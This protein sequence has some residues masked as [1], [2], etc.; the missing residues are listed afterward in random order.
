M[1]EVA[2]Q[3]NVVEKAP[4]AFHFYEEINIAPLV[5]LTT[6]D[7]AEDA[8]IARPVPRGDLEDFFALLA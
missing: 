5:C 8:D 2:D 3:C 6:R 4:P 7:G 1:F